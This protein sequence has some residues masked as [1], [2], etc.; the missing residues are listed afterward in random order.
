MNCNINEYVWWF[1]ESL[2]CNF[3][4]F[5]QQMCVCLIKFDKFEVLCE[6]ELDWYEFKD[7]LYNMGGV[8]EC[9]QCYFYKLVVCKMFDVW[10]FLVYD[11]IDSV[12]G[13]QQFN[14]VLVLF[15]LVFSLLLL[16]LGW[17]LVLKVMKLVL[18]L[19]VWLCVYCGG[20]SEFELLVLCFFDDEV[21]QLVQVL[22]DYLLWL[23]E[24]VQCDCE[25]NVDVSYEL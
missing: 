1:Y 10:V 16:V 23:I 11:M 2:D 20:M 12:C 22:D 15:V 14:C 24:V 5:V 18:D 19:V 17:W 8:D 9:G 3:D 7:G 21:G 13:G 6:E 25:F 4:L